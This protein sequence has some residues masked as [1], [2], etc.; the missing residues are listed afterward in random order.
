[1]KFF[2]K[3]TFQTLNLIKINRSAILNNLAIFKK[4][5]PQKTPIPVLKSN[6]Y[7]HGILQIAEILQQAKLPYLAVDGY[8]E[9]FKIRKKFPGQKILVKGYIHP[10]NIKF[11]KT[12]DLA[13]VIQDEII[14]DEIGKSNKKFTIHIEINTGMNRHG[15]KLEELDKFLLKLKEYPNIK[16]EGTMSHL[17]DADDTTDNITDAQAKAFDTAV[18]IIN[19]QNYD[20]KYIHLGQSAGNLKEKSKYSNSYRLGIGLYGIN[21]LQK[22]DK[23]Y[24]KLKELQPALELT[25]TISKVIELQ[26]GDKVSYNGT[27]TANEEI[28]IGV[29]PLGYYEGIDRRLSNKGIIK[30]KN[31]CYQIAGRVCMNHTMINFE[32]AKPELY[33]EVIIISRN[34][35]DQNSLQKICDNNGLFPYEVLV[36]LSES[37]RRILE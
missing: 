28:N 11:L 13:Y 33:D 7:G 10:K 15:L 16:L 27:F 32:L 35:T 26:K 5:N 19:S 17:S 34:K 14:L 20:L 23:H 2:T 22:R 6:A 29:L 30:Y 21:P 9:A 37:I 25:S 3:N 18:E 4:L 12:K 31:K 24:K 8:F 1:M 36:K